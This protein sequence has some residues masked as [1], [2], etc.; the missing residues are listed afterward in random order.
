MISKFLNLNN[1]QIMKKI[2]LIIV[3]SLL[4][5][6]CFGFSKPIEVINIQPLGKVSPE[7]IEV[8]KKSVKSFYGYDCVV[9]KR[10][11]VTTSILSKV[12]KRIDAD[13]LLDKYKSA[14]NTMIITEKD[15]CHF[16]D[17]LRPEYGIFGLGL[18]PGK[19]CV[20]STFRLKR[21]VNKQKTYER[22]GKVAIHEIGHN[23][24]LYHCTNDKQCLMND[25][26]GTIKQV[27]LGR[28][29]FCEKCM[30]KIKN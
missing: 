14:Q 25:A 10:I 26:R 11:D 28:V 6:S 8:V 29:W 27:D 19:I 15:I 22:L 23:L 13:K 21:K 9:K 30:A 20:I 7:Y 12:T 24:G 1:P 17:K 4:F 3:T 5:F 16:K 18:R 2:V